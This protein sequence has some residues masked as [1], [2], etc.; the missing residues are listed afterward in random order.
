MPTSMLRWTTRCTVF[1]FCLV[2]CALVLAQST[3]GRILGRVADP[4]GAVL[5]G[6]KVTLTNEATG[7]SRDVQ[8]NASGDYT[9]VEVQ[10]GTYDVAF[11]QKGFKK[12]LQKAVTV[13][14]NQVVTLNSTMQ[15]GAAQ[16]VVEVTSEAPLV[17][18]TSTQ[19]GTVVNER[20]IV[21]LP[22]NERD[23]YQFL[24][25]QP[26]VSSQ[27]GADLYYG[28]NNVGSVSVNGGRGR[29]NNFSVNGGDANDM[30][31]N[32]P[33]VQ[34]SPDS[35]EEFRILTNTFDAE[36]GR[37]SGAVVNVV[38]KSGTNAFHG[39]IYEFNRNKS[40]NARGYFDTS[41]PAFV[42]NQFGGTIGG[43]I[44]KD[45][46]FFFG[47]YEGLRR[48]R[49]ISGDTV[50]VPTAD[51]RNGDFS[52]GGTALANSL[53][54]GVNFTGSIGDQMVADVLNSRPGCA[55][56]IQAQ[57]PGAVVAS[58][59]FYGAHLSDPTNPSSP[60]VPGIFT[61]T[62][63]GID[64]Q[65]PIPCQDPVARDLL[66]FVPLPNTANGFFQ[67]VLTGT[68]RTD[69]TTVRIDHHINTKQTF[70]GYYY[71]TDE[72]TVNPFNNF[73]AAGANVPG[74]GSF[75][76]Q[77]FQQW[78][79][80]HT[81]TLSNS[82]VNEF[83]FAYMREAQRT[84]NHSQHTNLVTDS[85]TSAV[86]QFCFTGT[87]DSSAVNT[88][89]TGLLGSFAN[90]IG[91]T[92]GLGPNREGVPDVSVS[93]GFTLGNN[94][95][96]EL[97]QVGNSFQWSDNISKVKGNHTMKFGADVRRMR[98]D[99]TLYFEVS[100][101]Y[102]Y[103]GGGTNDAGYSDL[104]PNYLLGLPDTYQQ[105]AAQNENVRTTGV[106]LFGQDSWKIRPNL[107]LNYG[108]RWELN[109]PL[110]DIGHHVQTFRPGQN[111][112]IYPCQISPYGQAVLGTTDC[113]GVFPTGLVV[114]GD[115]GVPNGMT[116]T[117]YKAFAPRIGVAWS[118]GN[119]GRTS[120]HAGWGMF[121]NPVEQLVLEQF[122]AEPPFGGSTFLVSTFFNTP[123]FPQS[124]GFVYP[125]P[126][127]GILNPPRGQPV[128][129]SVFR[130]ILLFGEFQPHM[131]SQYSA[132]YNFSIQRELARDLSLE[133]G[134]VGS[135]GHRLLVSNDLNRATPQTC[136]DIAAIANANPAAVQSFGA[137]GTCNQF[138]E[139][140]QFSVTIPNGFNFHMPNG[141]TVAGTGQT[142]NFV[143]IRPYSSPN[144]NPTTVS[145]C[146]PDSVPVFS[147]IFAQDT[148]ANSA[149]NS[150]QVDVQKRFSHG[151]QLQGAYTFGKSID[152]ASSFEDILNPF[153]PRRTRSQS[154]FNA[155]HRF[156][157]SYYYE[158]PIPKFTGV[159]GKFLNGW[160]VSGITQFQSG[161]PI[162]LQS[163]D[164]N[165]L[166]SSIDFA[167]AGEPD[168]IAPFH[169][170]DPRSNPN[171]YGFAQNSF[172]SNASDPSQPP[173]S[174]GAVFNC[175]QPS[176]FG[177]Y[178]TAPR[179]IC[180]GP[181][182]NNWDISFQKNTPI[183]ERMR[184]EFRWDI[185]NLAN[186][187]RFFNPDGNVTDGSDFGR[188][189]RAADPRLMQV[190]L[191]LYF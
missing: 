167:S 84:F 14:I 60:V 76:K 137:P 177:R 59:S 88:A 19:L 115:K 66:R 186:H 43:P 51:E 58:G 69:Q 163:F 101:F 9:F 140:N 165:E 13:E 29:S 44:K 164:D 68:D 97:P 87:S 150:L 189:K 185:F 149:Y 187:T 15:L 156:V 136:L 142:L 61:N 128:D 113:S 34:P 85:C 73:Q 74:F 50:A 1:L 159:A 53:A 173:C 91:I 30:F 176:L 100:G 188:V 117:Y 41:K 54:S 131:R 114:P 174:A 144:C 31:V 141:T 182:L 108:L 111:T 28:S 17:D 25:L 38:T 78:N 42:M 118:P 45:K 124:G 132:Q 64:N 103:F 94:F 161:F 105:G 148:I 127:N 62:V 55:A 110:T 120:I 93:G 116:Q 10:P 92:P 126:F 35:V 154:L 24:S 184:V 22:L 36:Y 121:Y 63:T 147:N 46:T 2:N 125:N 95:E 6:V 160:A 122:S 16:E 153:D 119:S 135:Q 8:S 83:R 80:S 123:F 52:Q 77:R 179:T 133:V 5:S 157:L 70:S 48:H 190:A 172:T 139:D 32:L 99:Q 143:G 37:N 20:A 21:Q 107:T 49:G 162:H 175:Y 158:L 183:N 145:G 75:S 166:T 168:Q 7:V 146:P 181:G 155:L 152:Q 98:F 18:T 79:L 191:K 40:L 67:A 170:L 109:T 65:V 169:K 180:C 86:A 11:E 72:N 134:Y 3:G 130:P 56:A 57:N 71:F 106:Y 12:N 171:N 82:V 96:G 102:N 33:T 81:W 178:G 39:N 90:K 104:Y 26:G 151:L 23:T 129:W 138:A 27:T 4:S 47:S 112:T 89:A